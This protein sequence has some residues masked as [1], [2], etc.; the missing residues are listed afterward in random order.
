MVCLNIDLA[1]SQGARET[2]LGGKA[3]NTVSR[4]DVLDED[5]LVASS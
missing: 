3:F 1:S 2:E 4:V 5:D